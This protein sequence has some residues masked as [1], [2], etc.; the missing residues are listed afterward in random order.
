[1]QTPWWE[2]VRLHAGGTTLLPQ[3]RHLV[4]SYL[5]TLNETSR[6]AFTH[7]RASMGSDVA[8]DDGGSSLSGVSEDDWSDDE[9]SNEYSWK[10]IDMDLNRLQSLHATATNLGEKESKYCQHGCSLKRIRAVLDRPSCQ[11]KCRAPAKTVIALCKAFWLL[12]KR[13]QDALLWSLQREARKASKRR[14]SIGGQN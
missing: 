11:C 8:S 9:S 12:P 1:M 7:L 14:W 6:R 2:R 4:V 10:T 5:L 13:T 3:T